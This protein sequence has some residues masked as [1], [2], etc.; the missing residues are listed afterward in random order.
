MG[1]EVVNEEEFNHDSKAT[2]IRTKWIFFVSDARKWKQTQLKTPRFSINIGELDPTQTKCDEQ[3]RQNQIQDVDAF[4]D[5]TKTWKLFTGTPGYPALP[6]AVSESDDSYVICISFCDLDHCEKVSSCTR[7]STTNF[8]RCMRRRSTMSTGQSAHESRGS[9]YETSDTPSIFWNC[10]RQQMNLL[11][12]K[13]T[14]RVSLLCFY[15][16]HSVHMIACVEKLFVVNF[17][18]S[19]FNDLAYAFIRTCSN[20]ETEEEILIIGVLGETNMH[21]YWTGT[22]WETTNTQGHDWKRQDKNVQVHD[23]F[24]CHRQTSIRS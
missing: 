13:I 6:Y 7:D 3:G 12:F 16:V 15:Y 8:N 1:Y 17:W 14:L 2:I 4:A 5:D 22:S 18:K 10:L 19:K 11:L 24:R 20:A 9:K 21:A 23:F